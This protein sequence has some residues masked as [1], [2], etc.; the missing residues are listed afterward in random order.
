MTLPDAAFH[1]PAPVY[2]LLILVDLHYMFLL[3]P[4]ECVCGIPRTRCTIV[5]MSPLPLLGRWRGIPERCP[6]SRAGPAR[7][8]EA[9]APLVRECCAGGRLNVYLP[10]RRALEQAASEARRAPRASLPTPARVRGQVSVVDLPSCSAVSRML[11]PRLQRRRTD[12][13]TRRREDGLATR[14][15]SIGKAL[16]HVAECRCE[17]ARPQSGQRKSRRISDVDK[18]RAHTVPKVIGSTF[19]VWYRPSITAGISQRSDLP[20]KGPDCALLR[21]RVSAHKPAR[22]RC[23]PLSFNLL[24]SAWRNAS[25]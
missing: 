25:T 11:C 22:W 20:Y 7:W 21:R 12:P 16:T 24:Y 23:R 17:S 15:A 19:G 14:R 9:V 3:V 18:P 5:V 2:H 6:H 10:A 1:C 8:R 13:R 4:A